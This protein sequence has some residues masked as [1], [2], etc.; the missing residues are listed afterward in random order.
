M[1]VM[2]IVAVTVIV[3]VGV[4]GMTTSIHVIIAT[5]RF[6]ACRDA[7]A[8]ARRLDVAV[9]VLPVWAVPG[10]KEH[11]SLRPRWHYEG[12]EGGELD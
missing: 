2:A 12:Y 4:V 5:W 7:A 8:E 11:G 9:P 10:G 1:L 3:A 6:T